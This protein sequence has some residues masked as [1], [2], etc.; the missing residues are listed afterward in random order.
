MKKLQFICDMKISKSY[1][2]SVGHCCNVCE[3][4]ITG[5]VYVVNEDYYCEEHFEARQLRKIQR[6]PKNY[7]LYLQGLAS[8]GSCAKCG[9]NVGPDDSLS[10]GDLLFHHGC[11]VCVVCE[12]NME[13]KQITLDTNNRVYCTEDYDR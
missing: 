1:F 5:E 11:L 8:S 7:L 3:K 13:G 2:Q 9:G 10:V 12:R 6:Q 4:I